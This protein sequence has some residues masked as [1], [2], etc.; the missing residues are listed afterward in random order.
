[1]NSVWIFKLGKPG[2]ECSNFG[3]FAKRSE[4]FS[5]PGTASLFHGAMQPAGHASLA[6]IGFLMWKVLE[7]PIVGTLV[8][9]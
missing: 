1:M 6:S 8:Q 9:G 7:K 5:R 2:F 3:N 4:R